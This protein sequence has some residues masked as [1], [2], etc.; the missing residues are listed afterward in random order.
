M[1]DLKAAFEILGIAPSTDESTVRRAW[2]AL[3]RAYHP[4]MAKTDPEG[5]NRRLAE[6]NAAFDAVCA[7]SAAEVRLLQKAHARAAR[8]AE[9]RKRELRMAQK[10][11]PAASQAGPY[12]SDTPSDEPRNALVVCSLHDTHATGTS[13]VHAGTDLHENHSRTRRRAAQARSH[14]WH[15]SDMAAQAFE[16][17]R[18]I[19]AP[20]R[21]AQTQSVYF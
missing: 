4:D 3:V 9:K 17:A 12:P 16:A 7:C 15:I 20:Q 1:H 10:R 13:I 6:I 18:V 14:N 5:A 19:C 2:R 11:V 21:H 8:L